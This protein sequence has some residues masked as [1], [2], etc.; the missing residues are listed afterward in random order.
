L[1]GPRVVGDN[2]TMR[3]G[4]AARIVLLL[5]GIAFSTPAAPPQTNITVTVRNPSDKPVDNAEVIL[6][7]LGSHHQVTKLGRRKAVHWEMHTNQE[8]IAHF[9][10]VP[11]GT[12]Q[13]Q[14]VAKN[15]QTFGDRV[16][17]DEERK[18]IDVKLNPPQNQYSAH[19]PLKPADAPPA[20]QKQ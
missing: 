5:G 17:V 15:Y 13:L 1:W 16:D 20:Q 19:P 7:F 18:T 6:D 9:P 3:I 11:Q 10:P 12:L 8:G 2:L 14:V 4:R